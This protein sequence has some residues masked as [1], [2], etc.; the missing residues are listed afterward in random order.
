MSRL[1]ALFLVLISVV[2]LLPIAWTLLAAF[3]LQPDSTVSPP[4]WRGG[5]SLDAFAEIGQ[6]QTY[7]WLQLGTSLLVSFAASALA[8]AVGFLAAYGLA[9]S[10]LRARH[11][12]VQSLLILASLPAIAYLLTLRDF[13][14][15]IRLFDTLPGVILAQA[16][17]LA[18]L[19]A[20]VLYGYI[21]RAPVDVEDAAR[22]DGAHLGSILWYVVLPG[23][24]PGVVATTIIL[25]ILSYNQFFL[26]LLLTELHIR[27]MPVIVRDFFTLERDFEWPLAA[28]IILITIAPVLLL[29]ALAHRSL[30][31][32][33]FSL[34]Q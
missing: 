22:L 29:A 4:I 16:T 32:F 33:S 9:R 31:R 13:L 8:I 26:P 25:F 23:Q 10:V 19:A 24:M 17:L 3:G 6:M 21:V 20:F 27:M 28:A 11:V 18:P 2:C 5:L 30:Q 34:D 1:R 15:Y 14:R 12:I 7:F